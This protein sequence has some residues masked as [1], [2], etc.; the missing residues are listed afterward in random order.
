MKFLILFI[1]VKILFLD[2]FEANVWQAQEEARRTNELI[3]VEELATITRNQAEL[4]GQ[5]WDRFLSQKQAEYEDQK[6]SETYEEIIKSFADYKKATSAVDSWLGS[7]E[8][9]EA[10]KDQ[11]AKIFEGLYPENEYEKYV[12]REQFGKAGINNMRGLINTTVEGLPEGVF[13]DWRDMG[14]L[15]RIQAM[16]DLGE[17]LGEANT[18]EGMAARQR[19]GY[20][21]SPMGDLKPFNAF[22]YDKETGQRIQEAG[23]ELMKNLHMYPELVQRTILYGINRPQQDIVMGRGRETTLPQGLFEG[24]PAP[25]RTSI[26]GKE[27]EM[28]YGP[29]PGEYGSFDTSFINMPDLSKPELEEIMPFNFFPEAE[30]YKPD[31]W[32]GED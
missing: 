4:S 12:Q 1:A 8:I 32:A 14:T 10:G 29:P 5:E 19:Q 6:Y 15:E 31:S 7:T 21:F 16:E 20:A 30:P 13:S 23:S 9:S 2:E 25:T 11:L 17:K 24:L 18:P 26:T 22:R 28:P 27:I 3:T